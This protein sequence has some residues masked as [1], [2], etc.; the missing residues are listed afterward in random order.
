[1]HKDGLTHSID[2]GP[3]Y[4]VDRRQRTIIVCVFVITNI[5]VGWFSMLPC[6]RVPREDPTMIIMSRLL[7]RLEVV[8]INAQ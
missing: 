5:E 1:M 6:N 8:K 2:F 7:A 3:R 4:I